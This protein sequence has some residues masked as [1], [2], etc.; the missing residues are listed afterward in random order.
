MNITDNIHADI[1]GWPETL[2]P[3]T[4]YA[5]WHCAPRPFTMWWSDVYSPM[6]TE[7]VHGM[8]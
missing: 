1:D 4:K 8:D 3:R 6:C 2:L 5:H 7:T